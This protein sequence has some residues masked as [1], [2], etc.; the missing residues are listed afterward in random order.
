MFEHESSKPILSVKKIQK[1]ISKTYTDTEV[2]IATLDSI[3]KFTGRSFSDVLRNI[4]DNFI[5]NGR[6]YEPEENKYYTVKEILEI[7]EKENNNE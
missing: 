7:L 4:V 5:Q 6:I 2:N 1:T 3:A